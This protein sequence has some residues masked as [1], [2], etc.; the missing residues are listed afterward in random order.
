MDD[1]LRRLFERLTSA[2]DRV[3]GPA[4]CT[5]PLDVLETSAG[6]EVV[7][8]LPGVASAHVQVVLARNTLVIMGQKRPSGCEHHTEAAFHVAERAFGRF[9]RGVR[10]S[11][12]FDAGRASALLRDGELRVTL[13]R[14][15]ERRG[16]ERRIPVQTE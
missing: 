11:G 8:D 14:I 12:A 1:E 3:A 4:E 6:I 15:E 5:L 13:P 2:D 7:M 9:V 16:R 10:L